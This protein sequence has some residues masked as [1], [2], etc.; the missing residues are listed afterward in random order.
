M[1]KSGDLWPETVKSCFGT[2]RLLV[3]CYDAPGQ[4]DGS[5]LLPL[6][7]QLP[8]I[9]QALLMGEIESK[10]CSQENVENRV[11]KIPPL[12]CRRELR[13]AH[14]VYTPTESIAQEW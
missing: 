3:F 13:R 8:N 5:G 10:L 4:Q 9:T 11:S 7:F 2:L 1:S 14:T 12:G 6:F